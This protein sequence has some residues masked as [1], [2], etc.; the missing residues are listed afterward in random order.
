[1]QALPDSVAPVL[2][3]FAEEEYIAR[4][5]RFFTD[6]DYTNPV[7]PELHPGLVADRSALFDMINGASA[8]VNLGGVMIG[9][10]NSGIAALK[11]FARAMVTAG[12]NIR[13][14]RSPSSVLR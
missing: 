8:S 3:E 14:T 13:G 10:D 1:M 9:A 5:A 4:T 2:G 11:I 12:Q 7:T 6:P